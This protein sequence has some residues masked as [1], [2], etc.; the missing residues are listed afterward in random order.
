LE[1]SFRINDGQRSAENLVQRDV[2]DALAIL[3][4]VDCRMDLRRSSR[5]YLVLIVIFRIN[6]SLKAKCAK[7]R[8]ICV[9]I[10]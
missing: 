7:H 1:I 9:R 3:T 8:P 10:Q 2:L 4:K 5:V 6:R